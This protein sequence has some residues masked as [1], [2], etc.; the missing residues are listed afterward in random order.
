M[1]DAISKAEESFKILNNP[2]FIEAFKKTEETFMRQLLESDPKDKEFR[3]HQYILLK[4]LK[5]IERSLRSF[6][7]EG[8]RI[9]RKKGKN[10]PELLHNL[11]E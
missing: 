2:V 6:I 11:D 7:R 10:P 9:T 8:E 5:E 3:E 1:K 4:S